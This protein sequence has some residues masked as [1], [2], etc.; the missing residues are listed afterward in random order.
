MRVWTPPELDPGLTKDIP[1]GTIVAGN[2]A[3][4]VGKFDDLVKRR[5]ENISN[6]PEKEDGMDV[7][8]ATVS[9]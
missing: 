5:I 9:V 4:V 1:E 7:E 2:P 3:K 6:R 8:L